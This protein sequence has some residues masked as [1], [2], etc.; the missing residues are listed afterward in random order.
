MLENRRAERARERKRAAYIDVAINSIGE[1]SRCSKGAFSA[2]C[3]QR[4]EQTA[5]LYMHPSLTRLLTLITFLCLKS[6]REKKIRV[7]FLRLQRRP[8]G[9]GERGGVEGLDFIPRP[10]PTSTAA[11]EDEK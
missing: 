8:N 1:L 10:P 11:P 2:V 4:A 5:T 6:E 9:G 3:V 7:E